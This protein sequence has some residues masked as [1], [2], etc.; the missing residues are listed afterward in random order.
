MADATKPL[1][2]SVDSITLGDMEDIEEIAGQSF[3]EVMALLTSGKAGQ[4]GKIG[5]PVKVLRAL[6]LVIYR[7]GNPNFTVNDARQVKVS[8][9]QLVMS[10]PDPTEPADGGTSSPSAIFG[11]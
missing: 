9:L 4:N 2:F 7:Q 8:E 1:R 6:V 5:I 3:D 10:E 11:G